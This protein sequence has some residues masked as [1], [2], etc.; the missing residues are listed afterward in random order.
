[1]LRLQHDGEFP[2]DE[3]IAIPDDLHVIRHAVRDLDAEI[4]QGRTKLIVIDPMEAHLS[5]TRDEGNSST[6]RRQALGPLEA[7]A[8]ELDL[9]ALLVHHVNKDESRSA[10]YRVLGTVANRNAP[11]SVLL[12]GPN[13]DEPLPEGVS[14]GAERVLY[15]DKHNTS[16]K[17]PT[18]LYRVVPVTVTE[19]NVEIQTARLDYLREIE[20]DPERVFGGPASAEEQSALDEAKQFLA[21]ELAHGPRLVAEVNRDADGL[22][23][24]RRTLTRA[25]GELGAESYRKGGIGED[26]KWWLRLPLTDPPREAETAENQPSA[27][28]ATASDTDKSGALSETQDPCGFESPSHAKSATRT[29]TGSGGALSGEQAHPVDAADDDYDALVGHPPEERS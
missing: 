25:R 26:G 12:F 9:A 2:W 23:V 13:P 7:L 14:V 6:R 22:G 27:K 19:G 18:Q 21:G 20:I 11:R 29:N 15:H 5:D 10:S 24:A 28:C 4:A 1:L 3:S 17:S 8:N 16:R